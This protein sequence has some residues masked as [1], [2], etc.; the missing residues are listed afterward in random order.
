MHS[1]RNSISKRL[2]TW[3]LSSD[4]C[5]HEWKDQYWQ[6]RDDIRVISC[7]E[8][9]KFIAED[10]RCSVPFGSPI[11]KCSSAAQEANLHSLT[12]KD[13]L[14][15]GFGKHSIPRQLVKSAGGTWTGIEQLLPAAKK[16]S[17]GKAGF[18]HVADIPFP[19]C[20]FDIVVGIQ[21]IEHWDEPLPVASLKT[22][23]S[24]GLE[25]IYRVLKPGGSIYFCAPIHLHGHEMFIT[26]DIERIRS[27]FEP[28]PWTNIVLEMWRENYFPLERYPTPGA[29]A[30]TWERAV[31]SY[32]REL[33]EDILENRSVMLL[34]IKAKKNKDRCI[35]EIRDSQI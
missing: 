23:H 9:P 13:L 8:C 30:K 24:A 7:N 34:T 16:A 5:A 32:P 26:R 11:R 3:R 19:D 27:L 25:E 18:G 21:S 29:D 12:G 4:D 28:L 31:T 33:L 35:D 20:T 1:L 10:V 15:I 17:I 6:A 14:E 22:G 2:Y